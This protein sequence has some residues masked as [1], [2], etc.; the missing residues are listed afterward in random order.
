MAEKENVS[1]GYF[2]F[3]TLLLI[4]LCM[5][6]M[7][8]KIVDSFGAAEARRI[9]ANYGRTTLERVN[10]ITA[11]LYYQVM[12]RETV[13]KLRRSLQTSDAEREELSKYDL[14]QTAVNWWQ[15]RIDVLLDLLWWTLR[16]I[17]FLFLFAPYWGVFAVL[18]LIHGYWSREIKKTGFEYASP[19]INHLSRQAGG[20]TFLS[21]I[22]LVFLPLPLE[23]LILFALLVFSMSCVGLAVANIQ[24]QI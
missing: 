2:I 10:E 24:K 17:T 16:R 22:V 3:A 14:G 5:L 13:R 8:G 23:P 12:P 21:A 7:P 20:F 15:S 19:V 18:C 9:E 1:V 6:L 4:V 11:E